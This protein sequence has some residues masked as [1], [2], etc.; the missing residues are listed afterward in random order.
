[1]ISNYIV[2]FQASGCVVITLDRGGEDPAGE[3]ISIVFNLVPTGDGPG[4]TY[5]VVGN[6]NGYKIKIIMLADVIM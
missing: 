5:L 4:P 2:A 1:M 3:G 6:T